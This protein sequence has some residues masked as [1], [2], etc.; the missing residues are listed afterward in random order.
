VDVD[1]DENAGGQWEVGLEQ[2]DADR[3]SGAK[4]YCQ[5]KPILGQMA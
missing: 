1:Q 4:V 5:E 3:R 2:K